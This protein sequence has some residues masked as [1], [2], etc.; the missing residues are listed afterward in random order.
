M[1]NSEMLD[2]L[3]ANSFY[4]EGAYFA[5]TSAPMLPIER[6]WEERRFSARLVNPATRRKLSVIIVGSG[7]AGSSAAATHG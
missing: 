5:D 4:I 3:D 7:L 6:R 1:A 2:S